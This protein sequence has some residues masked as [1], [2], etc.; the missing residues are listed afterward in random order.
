[1]ATDWSTIWSDIESYFVTQWNSYT[2]LH[3][4]NVDF[5][6][7][8]TKW[9]SLS[10]HPATETPSELGT[11]NRRHVGNVLFRA[12][13]PDNRGEVDAW[14]LIDKASNILKGQSIT[15]V[16]FEH[17]DRTIAK[18]GKDEETGHLLIALTVPFYKD[19]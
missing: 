19:V 16:S 12:F 13:V 17:E 8:A 7:P 4:S 6:P 14:D 15:G 9:G 3:L 11:S 10:I 2:P 18:A 1:M 5:D